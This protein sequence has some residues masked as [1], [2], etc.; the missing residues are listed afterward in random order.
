MSKVKD[1]NINIIKIV[2]EY[3]NKRN[4]SISIRKIVL[5]VLT[6]NDFPSLYKYFYN[7]S[8]YIYAG[9]LDCSVGLI[10]VTLTNP[11]I[12]N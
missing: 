12:L 3:L 6:L 7:S 10:S 5:I 4:Q 9:Y 2:I 1:I 8:I 11:K